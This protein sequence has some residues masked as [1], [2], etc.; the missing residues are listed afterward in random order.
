MKELSKDRYLGKNKH[1]KYPYTRSLKTRT[2][3]VRC[4][5]MEEELDIMGTSEKWSND[6]NQS[7]SI[8]L[9]YKLYNKDRLG[10]RGEK[11]EC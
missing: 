3:E 9:V 1:P 10:H 6:K 7:G 8:I 2:G 4:L 11:G 5:E